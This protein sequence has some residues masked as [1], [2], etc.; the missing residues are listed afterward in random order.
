MKP[1]VTIF[2]PTYNRAHLLTRLYNSLV[3]QNNKNFE[4][5]IVDDGSTDN[6]KELVET[7][8]AQDIIKIRYYIQTNGGKHTAINKGIDGAKGELF[9]IVDSDDFLPANSIQ[10]ITYF[11]EK[12]ESEDSIAGI[13]G[14]K[15]IINDNVDNIKFDQYEFKSS[16]FDI[17]YKYNYKGDMAEVIKT[18]VIKEFLF[19]VF[20]NEKFCTEAVV[21]N[22]ISQN[23]YC[24]FFD[25]FIYHCEY[26]EGGLTSNYWNLLLNNPKGSLLYFKELLQFSLNKSQK[27]QTLKAYNNIAKINGYSKLKI[28]QELGLINFIKIYL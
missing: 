3:Q 17:R 20:E 18:S 1:F 2:T 23:Y 9:F 6:T 26:Q 4:W 5:L 27:M 8:I 11:Y 24:L 21:W 25:E 19:P 16:F 14:K 10:R 7:F 22:R 13:V 15:L 12:I 28:I